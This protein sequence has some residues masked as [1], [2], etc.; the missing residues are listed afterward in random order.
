MHVRGSGRLRWPTTSIA[1]ADSSLPISSRL[2]LQ[3]ASSPAA[4]QLNIL[5]LA[6]IQP[7]IVAEFMD[8][9]QTDLFADFGFAGA[10]RFNV[11]LIKHDV[12][13]PRRQV[14]DALPGHG[15]SMENAESQPPL[16]PRPRR[17]LVRRR[18]LE[19]NRN[20]MHATAK[21]LRERVEHLL[22][23]LGETFTLHPSP[24]E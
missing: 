12:I 6:L 16:L 23:Y 20:V 14:K 21:F 8:D 5:E 10:D 15:Y 17:W 7:E 9:R 3:T 11:L 2:R 4:S 24:T 13:G 19:Q 22:D 1:M 18:I